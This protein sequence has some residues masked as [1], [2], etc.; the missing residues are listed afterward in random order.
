MVAEAV[1]GALTEEAGIEVVGTAGLLAEARGMV[2]R[3]APHVVLMDYRLP[4]GVGTELARA[5]TA[6][7]PNTKVVIVTAAEDPDVLTEAIESGC[8]GYVLKSRGIQELVDAVHAAQSGQALFPASLVT[9]VRL[10][11]AEESA[12]FDLTPREVEVLHLLS[13]GMST[14]DMMDRLGV[15][16]HTVRN[17][18]Q[19][20]IE[21]LDAHSKVEAVAIGRR[22][23][24]IPGPRR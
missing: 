18:V 5:I 7:R 2:G 10:R 13:E 17:Y 12:P 19:A 20:V 3:L 23:G 24:V 11:Q 15:R 14:R 9:R 22:Q 16:F 4:D 6:E 1:A 21:K 8:A